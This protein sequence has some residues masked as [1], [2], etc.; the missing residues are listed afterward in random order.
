MTFKE[1]L[2]CIFLLLCAGGIG[3]IAGIVEK[4]L[5]QIT[6]SYNERSAQ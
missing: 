2:L 6:I 3:L 4:E 1:I 5:R